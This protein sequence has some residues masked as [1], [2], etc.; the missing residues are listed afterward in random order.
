MSRSRFEVE[1]D[2]LLGYMN[3]DQLP[4]AENQRRSVSRFTGGA[5][6]DECLEVARNINEHGH[7][8]AID[9]LS[10]GPTDS[11]EIARETRELLKIIQGIEVRSLT[12]SVSLDLSQLGL[13]L[14]RDLFFNNMVEVAQAAE[15]A[16]L[17]LM[18]A[19]GPEGIDRAIEMYEHLCYH[20]DKVGITLQADLHRTPADL[21]TVI[22]MPGRIRLVSA[23]K[24]P[25]LPLNPTDHVAPSS[26]RLMLWKLLESQ[27]ACCIAI[28]DPILLD[29]AH[30]LIVKQNL[31]FHYIHFELPY[32]VLTTELKS[33]RDRGYHT[34][35]SIPYGLDWYLYICQ[36]L[37]E[38]GG[39]S[40][41]PGKLA[42]RLVK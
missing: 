26:Y 30:T 16:G 23:A 38:N 2:I 36:K 13:P 7:T 31:A 39:G 42:L 37:A 34:R 29:E 21:A 24:R 5:T 11:S 41:N 3:A 9:Y 25:G 32:G 14:D 8:V 35:V 33:M 12:A 22:E 18:I 6:L 19:E 20:F 27:H 10:K 15:N 1:A 17:E 40:L 28:Q 4:H